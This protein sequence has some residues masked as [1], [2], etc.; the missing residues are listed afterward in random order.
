MNTVKSNGFSSSAMDE[1]ESSVIHTSNKIPLSECSLKETY[2]YLLGPRHSPACGK[3]TTS[4]L[5]KSPDNNKL[6]EREKKMEK[7][8]AYAFVQNNKS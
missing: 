7:E 8:D 4:E 6:I 3:D 5:R 1:L 2:F